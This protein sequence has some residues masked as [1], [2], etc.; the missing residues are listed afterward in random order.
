MLAD[1]VDP[2]ACVAAFGQWQNPIE[3]HRDDLARYDQVIAATNPEVI[4]ECGTRSG[5]SARWFA[6]RGC[7]VVTIDTHPPDVQGAPRHDRLTYVGGNTLDERIFAVVETMVAGRRCM[8]S[9]DS[10]HS[11]EHLLQE[12]GLYRELVS[13]GCYLVVEDGVIDWLPSPKPHGCDVYTGSVLAA[14][15]ARL[16]GDDRFER[17]LTVEVL[18]PVTMFPA[19]WWVRRG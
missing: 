6:D 2:T 9:L 7:D 18:T 19:G 12:I 16:A 15:E 13:L 14:I 10:D 4:V 1:V 17:D 11:E 3:K 8:V 5:W